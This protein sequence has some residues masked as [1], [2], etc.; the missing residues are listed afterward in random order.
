MNAEKLYDAEVVQFKY[1]PDVLPET[2]MRYR[3]DLPG[4]IVE[5]LEQ[6]YP[7]AVDKDENGKPFAWNT[8]Y[9]IPPMLKLI[10]DQKKEIE[11]LKLDVEA[12]KGGK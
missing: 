12:L 7:V 2:D 8:R 11:Q 5:D 9:M 6:V 3:M 1:K 10:Q 4:F